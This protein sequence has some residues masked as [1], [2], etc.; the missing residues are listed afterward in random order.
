MQ[1]FLNTFLAITFTHWHVIYIKLCYLDQ[2]RIHHDNKRGAPLEGALIK[3]YI[4]IPFS[5][6]QY[7]LPPAMI[8]YDNLGRHY[9]EV[10]FPWV[11]SV[12][13]YTI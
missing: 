3:D 6:G 10:Q 11:F 4:H 12:Y 1:I 5:I 2:P 7:V 13:V 9:D 8:Y